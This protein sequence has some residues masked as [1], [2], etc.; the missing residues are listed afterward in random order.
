MAAPGLEVEGRRQ[1]IAG[2]KAA[3]AGSAREL[4]KLHR[5]IARHVQDSARA[6]ASGGS[7]MARAAAGN[8]RAR[9]TQTAASLAVVPSKRA[10]FARAAFFGARR[11]TGWYAQ[12]RFRDGPPQFAPWVG[13]TWD[14][15]RAGE[16][17]YVLNDAIR[18]DLPWVER[19]LLAGVDELYSRAFPEK[20]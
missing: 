12:A 13:N 5:E 15:A 17:P 7:R 20:R 6:R 18:G 2:L 1:F 16:G 14:V 19:R 10:P 4:A 8:I 11:H 3:E 9:G